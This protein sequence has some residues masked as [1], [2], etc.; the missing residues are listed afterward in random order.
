MHEDRLGVNPGD[1]R[2]FGVRQ[3]EMKVPCADCSRRT[4]TASSE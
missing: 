1:V 2:R 4:A 3:P